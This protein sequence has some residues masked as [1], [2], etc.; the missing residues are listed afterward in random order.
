MASTQQL[1]L[2][3]GAGGAEKNYIEDVFSTYLYT[4]TGATLSIV[5]NIDLSTKGGLTWFKQ[6]TEAGGSPRSHYLFDTA[7]GVLK[8]INTN[9]TASETTTAN[10]LTAFNTNGFTIGSSA[11]VNSSVENYVS[12]T[13]RKQAKFFDVV[14]YTGNGTS[15]NIAHNLGSTPGFMLVKRTSGTATGGITYHTSLGATKGVVIDLTTAAT[16]NSG[17]WN[18]TSP[19]STQFTV[20][21]NDTTNA[22]GSTYVA[23]LFAHN[24]GGFGLNGTDN[25]I[26]CGT[27]VGTGVAGNTITLGYEPQWLMTRPTSSTGAWTIVDN[28]R[29]FPFG[30][31]DLT[32]LANNVASEGNSTA[33]GATS[34]GFVSNSGNGNSAGVTFIY[35]AIRRGPMKVPTDATK[36]FIPSIASDD[37]VTTGFPVDFFWDNKRTGNASNTVTGARL[38]GGYTLVSSTTAAQVLGF[39]YS[40]WNEYNDKIALGSFTTNNV[41]YALQ[42]APTFFDVVCSKGTG[43]ARNITHNLGVAPELVINKNRTGTA[44][45][46]CVW[47]GAAVSGNSN[48]LFLNNT[49]ARYAGPNYWGASY[50]YDMN[51][52]TFSV[53]SSTATNESGAQYVTY[54]FATCAGVSKV[55]SYTGTGT[56]K[57]IDCGFAAGARFVLVKATST[58]GNWIVVDTARGLVSG[59]DPTLSL[60]STAAEVTTNDWFDP[61][62]AG[63][64]LSSAGGNLANTNGVSYIFLAIA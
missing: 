47:C 5:N 7:R 26:T 59:N 46:W 60:N 2:G 36:V 4:G 42:R 18:N 51:A 21:S 41:T 15:Q 19:T 13:F 12:W 57:Q 8:D 48:T 50:A 17:Y 49:Q 22:S 10:S 64:E 27:Y 24:A 16:T 37:S 32:L 14:T 30:G 28:M 61:Y 63:F 1:L 43:A 20:G 52:T 11:A 55:G 6:R 33:F 39:V 29:D 35:V 53:G 56:T 34:T 58:T 23:Y 62:S 44:N 54:L 9:E 25:V 3:E 40:Y 31:E 45:D 38:M